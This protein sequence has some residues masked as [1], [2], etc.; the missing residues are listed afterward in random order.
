MKRQWSHITDLVLPTVVI[1]GLYVFSYCLVAFTIKPV[2]AIFFPEVTA[3]ASLVFL[4]HGLKIFATAVLRYRAIPGLFIGSL[5]STYLIWGITEPGM[6]FPLAL[7][8]SFTT[9]AVFEGLMALRINPYYLTLSAQLPSLQTILLAGLFC[10]FAKGFLMA[11]VLESGGNLRHITL[12]MA[13]LVVGDM[14]GLMMAWL[15]AITGLKFFSQ[16]P[17]W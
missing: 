16:L 12:I 8:A 4:P 15:I 14:V 7:I 10:S 17:R 2:Q 1:A 9:C 5:L 6:L 13:A 3:Y 11:A